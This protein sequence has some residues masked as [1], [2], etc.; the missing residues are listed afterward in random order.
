MS[1][2]GCRPR[3]FG[4]EKMIGMQERGWC[5]GSIA[6]FCG[7]LVTKMK[8]LFLNKLIQSSHSSSFQLNPR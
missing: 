5:E 8:V 3:K 1:F 6:Q 2:L 7:A 4:L